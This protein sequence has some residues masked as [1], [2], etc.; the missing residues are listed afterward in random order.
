MQQNNDDLEKKQE[1]TELNMLE[2]E[3]KLKEQEEELNKSPPPPPAPKE[4][5]KS[6]KKK[7]GSPNLKKPAKKG[8]NVGKSKTTNSPKKRTLR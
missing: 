6:P 2:N 8:A 1:Q 3:W 7:D 4:E 5:T